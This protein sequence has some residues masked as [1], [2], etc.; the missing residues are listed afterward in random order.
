TRDDAV[1]IWIGGSSVTCVRGEIEIATS[2][3][4][5]RS[6]ELSWTTAP[7]GPARVDLADKEA[8]RRV[9]EPRPDPDRKLAAIRAAAAHAFPI[10]DIDSGVEEIERG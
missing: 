3:G 9:V 2:G 7:L 8:V 10:G 4:D 6:P 1:T 5:P